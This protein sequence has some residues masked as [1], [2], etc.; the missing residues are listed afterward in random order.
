MTVRSNARERVGRLYNYLTDR[1]RPDLA[2][3][4]DY[5]SPR[6]RD[7]WGGPLNGQSQRQQLVRD[8]YQAIPFTATI[9]TGSFRGHTTS[10]FAAVSGKPVHS[11]ESNA[12]YLEYARRNCAVYPN[13]TFTPGDSRPFLRRQVA[14]LDGP[15]FLYLDAHWYDDLPLAEEITSVAEAK[16]S[17]V[18]MIDDF[19]VPGDPGYWFDDYGD[20]ARL[21]AELLAPLPLDGWGR[22]YP[23]VASRDESGLRRGCV[24]LCSSDLVES[25]ASIAGLSKRTFSTS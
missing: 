25:T 3:R 15:L 14:S 7:G 21:T 24:V 16:K 22:F 4:I 6:F 10:F 17:A 19:E 5:L 18:I 12:R 1:M 23:S 8:L 13:V 2:A 11:V 9:E 20:G